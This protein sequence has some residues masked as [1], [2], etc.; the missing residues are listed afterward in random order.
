MRKYTIEYTAEKATVVR[1]RKSK[2]NMYRFHVLRRKSDGSLLGGSY[3][4]TD[5]FLT[6]MRYANLMK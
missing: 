6:A 2:Y 1:Y 3:F 4:E 5:D